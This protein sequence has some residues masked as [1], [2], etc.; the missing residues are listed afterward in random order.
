MA[1]SNIGGYKGWYLQAEISGTTKNSI[2]VNARIYA[3]PSYS[4]AWGARTMTMTCN[5]K[6]KTASINAMNNSGNTYSNVA[7]A[8]FTDL[9]P[10]T[11]YTVSFSY[12]VRATLSNVYQGT[13]SGS[14][15][16]TTQA[17]PTY[18]VNISIANMDAYGNYGSPWLWKSTTV[19]EGGS[20]SWTAYSGDATYNDLSYSK[21]S[22]TSNV[23]E[24][25]YASRKT[26]TFN[27]NILMPDD[28]EPYS[29]GRAGRVQMSTDGGST[30][31]DYI[32]NEPA[33]SYYRGRS[34][35]FRNFDPGEGLYLDSVSGVDSNWAVTQ[36]E[37]VTV[38]FHT[39]Y[40][41][42]YLDVNGLLDGASSG[43]LGDYGRATVVVN[44]STVGN[45]ISDYYTKH[46]YDYSYSI[47]N[48]TPLSGYRY[49][50]L[51][52]GS[53]AASGTIGLGKTVILNF[54]TIEP[55]NLQINGQA[56]T[57]FNIDLSWSSEGINITNYTVYYNGIAKDCGT[58]T[59][60]SIS[61]TPETTYD[62]Y[63]TATNAGG[64]TTSGTIS[65]TTPADQA[66]MRIRTQ[67]VSDHPVFEGY[68]PVQ[69]IT[70]TA[71]NQRIELDHDRFHDYGVILKLKWND[72]TTE[73]NIGSYH[74]G[75]FGVSNGYY[76][77]K[78]KQTTMP[79]VVGREDVVRLVSEFLYDV[80]EGVAP[81]PNYIYGGSVHYQVTLYV[82]ETAIDTYE[83]TSSSSMPSYS[84]FHLFGVYGIDNG[85]TA[86]IY[87]YS[88]PYMTL[89]PYVAAD[90]TP[91]FISH[92]GEV[93]GFDGE[94]G[95][96]GAGFGEWL[97]GK[98]YYKLNG[99]W[100]KAKKIY[101]KINGEW[102]A[103]TNAEPGDLTFWKQSHSGIWT[104]NYDYRTGLSDVTCNGRSGWWEHLYK[105]YSTEP[106]ATYTVEFDYYN[107]KGYSPDYGGIECQAS[108]VLENNNG[109]ERKIGYV[110]LESTASSSIQHLSFTFTAT[111]AETCIGFNF[112]RG[113]DTSPVNIH[114]G[115]IFV[116]KN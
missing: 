90:G 23:T 110:S 11:T 101:H 92:D 87:S 56:T 9:S 80:N 72:V 47:T 51:A 7:S 4:C 83:T 97:R 5:G 82:N 38:A 30:W 70:A 112:G 18:S 73:Q 8:T 31:S 6:T 24:T 74:G 86:S 35:K 69:Y 40:D 50:G 111:Q 33:G 34:L 55:S 52:S 21:S 32:S 42:Y 59:A 48:I 100:V 79:A 17:L 99:S 91:V 89:L 36:G 45:Q 15:S 105:I 57:P 115:N 1:Y 62:I 103:G 98:A 49:N 102:Q 107:P 67:T 53:S 46:R 41:S 78:G 63:F 84:Y 81:G 94:P 113:S 77:S 10:S 75:Y 29:T 22:I 76:T 2:S 61:V 13:W 27:L 25:I 58:S 14:L 66:K 19:S 96:V 3:S 88:D 95:K 16:A 64:T 54:T 26:G 44:G 106:G 12:D 109:D 43:G 68:T 37:A 114:I 116:R 20:V 71:L 60:T 65:I 108:N 85:S 28:S 104:I 93:Y 39:E